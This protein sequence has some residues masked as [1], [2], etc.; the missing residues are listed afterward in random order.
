MAEKAS[1][2]KRTLFPLKNLTNRSFR[3]VCIGVRWNQLGQ[4]G[5]VNI[6]GSLTLGACHTPTESCVVSHDLIAD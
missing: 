1:A 2:M 4:V 6:L 3:I 5:V